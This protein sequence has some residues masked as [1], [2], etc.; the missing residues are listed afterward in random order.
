[1]MKNMN[2]VEEKD[3]D[4]EAKQRREEDQ[5]DKYQYHRVVE[6]KN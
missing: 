4:G 5:K 6:E 1:M 3:H 2:K